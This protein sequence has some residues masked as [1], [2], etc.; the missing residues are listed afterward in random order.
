MQSACWYMN[1]AANKAAFLAK[2][3]VPLPFHIF[4]GP[5][6]ALIRIFG[7]P[8]TYSPW[9]FYFKLICDAHSI[10]IWN[11]KIQ[12]EQRLVVSNIINRPSEIK[13]FYISFFHLYDSQNLPRSS[14]FFCV[15]KIHFLSLVFD[16][17]YNPS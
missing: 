16:A 4:I 10:R 6:L 1:K 15:H 2:A 9:C 14:H 8:M 11:L 12:Q 3:F 7:A 13:R 5:C 17:R